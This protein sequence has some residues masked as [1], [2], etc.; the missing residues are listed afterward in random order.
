MIINLGFHS[1]IQG[2]PGL[3]TVAHDDEQGHCFMDG[4]WVVF[5]EIEG[6][7][8]LN[9]SK[10]RQ[11]CVKGNRTFFL[12]LRGSMCLSYLNAEHVHKIL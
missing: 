10:P 1:F 3:L 9:G 2:N 4:D 8:Q 7:T 12:S 5:S 6:M 11:I